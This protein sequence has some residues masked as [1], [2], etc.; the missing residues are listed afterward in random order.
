[1]RL[2]T[3]NVNSL[4]ARLER[5]LAWLDRV[6]PDVF[7]MQETKV[8]DEAVPALAFRE[9]GYDVA[10]HGLG[11]WNGVGIASRVGIQ[12]VAAGLGPAPNGWTDDGGRFIAAT[13]GGVRVVSVYVP[14]GR[15]VGSEFYEAK[16][17]WLDRL[18][19][20]VDANCDTAADMAVCGD[21]NVAPTDDDVWD[22]E[23]AHGATHVS[24]PERERVARLRE[25][26]LID[27]VR[28]F[29]PEPG[30]YT[31]W[32]YRAGHFHKNFGMRID[33]VYVTPAL[34]GRAVAAERDRDARKPKSL[35][36]IASDHAPL[37][38]DFADAA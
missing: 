25:R 7:C 32:D 16:L 23:A 9:L 17:A 12:D 10:H 8:A 5:V 29:H 4:S 21:F 13:C 3:W 2:A 20:W 1:M 31:W 35:P 11:R 33:H 34:A 22:A 6:R 24:P 37:Y 26:G 30:F 15:V 19:E 18:Y 36:G 14:N 28:V 27:V 38:V